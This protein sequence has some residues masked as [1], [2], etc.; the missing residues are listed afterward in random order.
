MAFHHVR[1]SHEIGNGN[2]HFASIAVLDVVRVDAIDAAASFLGHEIQHAIATC[3]ACR[4]SVLK[5]VCVGPEVCSGVLN[6]G[7]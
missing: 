7:A 6:L 1:A 2:L 3:V 5:A 4:N